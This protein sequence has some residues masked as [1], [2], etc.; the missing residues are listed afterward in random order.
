MFEQVYIVGAGAIGKALAVFLKTQGRNVTLIRGSVDQGKQ[1]NLAVDVSLNNGSVLSASVPAASFSDFRQLHGVIV[2]TNKSFGN[3]RIAEALKDKIDDAPVLILQNGLGIEQAFLD[4]GFQN[5]Y[6]CVLFAT[7]QN[8]TSNNVRFKPVS[9]SPIGVVK[10][11]ASLLQKAIALIDTP[12]FKFAFEPHIQPVIWKKVIANCVFNSICP[13]LEIDNGIFQRNDVAR[14][15]AVE[16]IHECVN[17]AKEVG[18]ILNEEDV[19]QTVLLISKSSDGQLISTLQDIQNKRETEIDSLNFAVVNIAE[20]LN[21][22][23]RVSKTRLM[24]QLTKLKSTLS[25]L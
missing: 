21:M 15:L 4:A 7:S 18:V 24:G 20:K 1:E 23:D 13:L 16:L 6:R 2:L 9:T 5:I 12:S 14:S 8:T 10:G 25:L 22:H 11:D 3:K 17:V 19:L